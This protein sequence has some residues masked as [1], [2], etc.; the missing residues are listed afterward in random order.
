MVPA[1]NDET[2]LRGIIPPYERKASTAPAGN[3]HQP[4]RGL[5]IACLE[6]T[7][8]RCARPLPSEIVYYEA[9]RGPISALKSKAQIARRNPY[10]DRT[11]YSR[12][13]A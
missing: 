6:T 2:K 13:S 9:A 8:A 1:I 3:H 10:D 11:L 5:T 7:S 12:N 4:M